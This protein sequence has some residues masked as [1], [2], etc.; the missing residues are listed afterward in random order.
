MTTESAPADTRESGS[1]AVIA[2]IMN[3]LQERRLQ[4]GDRLPSERDLAERLG[5]GRSAVRS[6]T[7]A[8]ARS[9]T[10]ATGRTCRSASWRATTSRRT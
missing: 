10:S 5:V 3:Y 7:K 4:P 9:N 1:S 2:G 6:A 8:A